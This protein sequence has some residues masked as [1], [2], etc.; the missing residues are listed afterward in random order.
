MVLGSMVSSSQED[1]LKKE[2][3]LEEVIIYSNKFAERKKNIVQKIDV[4]AARQIAQLNA[5]N[6]GDL[7][8]NT[9]NVFVQKS[10][11][12]GS[13]PVI[14]GFE[15]SRVLLVV[16]GIR[17]NNAIYR[18]GHLQSI[19]TVD[20]NMLE[21]IEVSYGPASTI[22]G[23]D[24]LGGVV[25]M[26][27][28]TPEL[29]T[30][31]RLF[32]TGTAFGRYSSANKE[33]T[34]HFDVSIGG[35]QI[36]WLQSY[37]FSDFEDTRMGDKYPDKYPNFGRRSQYVAR[38]NNID[39]IVVNSDDRIQKFSGYEQWD[40]THKF[41]FQHKN[42]ISHLVNLQYSASGNV[43]RYDRLQDV[44]NGLLR[45]AEWYYGPQKRKLGAYEI[46]VDSAGFFTDL[47]SIISYQQIEE[48][49]HIREYKKLNLDNQFEK[50]EVWNITLDGR[51]LWSKNELT[52]G[53]DAQFN[54]VRSTAIQDTITTGRTGKLNTRYPNGDNQMNYLGT[55]AQHLLKFGHGKFVL[56]DGIRLQYVS[57]HS[58]ITDNSFFLFPFTKIDQK[59]FAIT[60][61][62]GLVYMPNDQLRINA[63]LS[64]GFRSPNV[65]DVTKIFETST[66][67]R[68][69][70]IP[71]PR[72]KPE[73]TY[74]ADIGITKQIGFIQFEATV[75]YTHFRNAIGLAPF[76]LNGQDSIN[77]NGT[78]VRL[79]A[80]QNINQAFLYGFNSS[81]SFD[82]SNK[83][84]LYST[85]NY[86]YGRSMR[87]DNKDLP[88]DHVPPLYGKTNFTFITKLINAEAYVLYNGWK[89][90]KHY[91]PDGEDNPQ[92]AT[93]DGTPAWFTLNLK[94]T[95]NLSKHFS[96]QAGIENFL[97]RN[98]R[99]FASG[100]SAPGRNC[101]LAIRTK[102]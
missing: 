70:I 61:N 99:Y 46:N 82:I 80:N 71:N 98:Y 45:Y 26:R 58:T 52:L 60:G 37:N 40:I 9:G 33:K 79:F 97:D 23:S 69:L 101:I 87:R 42:K 30:T 54:E 21:R 92:Y 29:S 73:Y 19:I 48:S 74:N 100:F 27:T 15:A 18:A 28:K 55:Y 31:D 88:L 20:Q 76:Q 51:K 86:T 67:L 94:T 24:A 2:K 4:I 6:T 89:R 47:K 43:P 50:V 49:R 22:F 77:Y 91:N 12:G 53:T 66:A 81:I 65:D 85:I 14:R 13:S 62:L 83:F 59:N 72:I 56:N 35:K 11:Q 93:P 57:L 16:D 78:V 102:F 8:V 84:Q 10:Q 32:I 96:L 68:Q 25:H 95:F 41:L 5:Q 17:M 63:G 36:T 34:G 75:F 7:L 3:R 44:R 64:S 39:S 90:I 38:I 1:S